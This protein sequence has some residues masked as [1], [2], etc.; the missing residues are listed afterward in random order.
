MKFEITHR[1]R[2]SYGGEVFLEPTCLRLKPRQDPAQ[3]L[4]SYSLSVSP[5]PAGMSEST[6]LFGNPQAL[7]WFG[8]TQPG[9]SLAATSRVETRLFDPFQ[10]LVTD[11]PVLSLPARYAPES[12]RALAPYLFRPQAGESVDQFALALSRECVGNTLAFLRRAALALAGDFRPLKRPEGEPLPPPRTLARGEGACRDLAA[13][14]IDLCRSLG[15]AARFVSGYHCPAG[16][17]DAGELHAWAEVYL[18]GAGWRGWDPSLG[19]AVADRHV[20]LA[21]GPGHQ[22]VAPVWGSYRGLSA[23]R[24]EYQVEMTELG[25]D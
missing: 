12:R 4:E 14:F 3:A 7:L 1:L 20:A 18:P 5:R 25:G 21:A 8:R 13:L 24:L 17:G 6:D 2:Y 15:L 16:S 22:D 11:L 19:L 10:Y 9:L 23:S